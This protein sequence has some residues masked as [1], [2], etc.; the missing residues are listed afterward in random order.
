MPSTNLETTQKAM[1]DFKKIQEYD[2]SK[3][4]KFYKDIC[5]IKRRI[6]IS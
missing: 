1:E 2:I 5:K 6:Y 3:R 4:R